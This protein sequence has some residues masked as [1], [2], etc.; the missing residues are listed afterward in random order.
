MSLKYEPASEPVHFCQEV[1]LKFR[2]FSSGHAAFAARIRQLRSA[3]GPGLTDVSPKKP[4]QSHDQ[5]EEEERGIPDA[6]GFVD[7]GDLRGR[8]HL[9]AQLACRAV[10]CWG[11]C[12]FPLGV[13]SG[14]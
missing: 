6:E 14:V 10:G 3:K 9:H 1:V 2:L 8:R 12:F 13:G 5:E 7:V 11:S 4:R